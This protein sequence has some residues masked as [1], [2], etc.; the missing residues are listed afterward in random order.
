MDMALS[1]TDTHNPSMCQNYDHLNYKHVQ[2]QSMINFT[3]YL[4]IF[5]RLYEYSCLIQLS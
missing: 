3:Q 2:Q 1:L 5:H 4:N